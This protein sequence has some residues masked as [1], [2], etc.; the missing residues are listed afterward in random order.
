MVPG[1]ARRRGLRGVVGNQ[2][3]SDSERRESRVAWQE[4]GLLVQARGTMSRGRVAPTG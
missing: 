2:R 4:P 1:R 3:R